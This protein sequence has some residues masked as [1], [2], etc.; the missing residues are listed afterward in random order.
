MQ[1]LLIFKPYFDFFLDQRSYPILQDILDLLFLET[2]IGE[3]ELTPFD[4]C[5]DY[6]PADVLENLI[7]FQKHL[8]LLHYR[9]KKC[10]VLYV[11]LDF[12]LSSGHRI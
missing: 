10:L 8:Y 7:V 5:E 11:L 4:D 9:Q 2:D 1:Y 3:A 12:L 6:V